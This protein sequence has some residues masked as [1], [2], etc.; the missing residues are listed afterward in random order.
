VPGSPSFALDETTT[1]GAFGQPLETRYQVRLGE[2]V[3][4]ETRDAA[5]ANGFVAALRT[6]YRTPIEDN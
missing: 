4:L 3:L 6:T 1:G 5:Q 2:S